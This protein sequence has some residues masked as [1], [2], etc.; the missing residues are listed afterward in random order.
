[1]RIND[2]DS[3]RIIVVFHLNDC[4]ILPSGKEMIDV[5]VKMKSVVELQNLVLTEDR[6][7]IGGP[8]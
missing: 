6:F 3:Q 2:L 5:N 1:M 8:F 4:K 7:I